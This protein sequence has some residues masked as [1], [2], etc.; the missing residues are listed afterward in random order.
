M[1]I[2]RPNFLLIIS[3][4]GIVC[5]IAILGNSLFRA[6]YNNDVIYWNVKHPFNA[7][8][9]LKLDF[10]EFQGGQTAE[11]LKRQLPYLDW[12]CKANTG[13]LGDR[14]CVDEHLSTWNGNHA[15]LASFWFTND[16]LTHISV[17]IPQDEHSQVKRY[18]FTLL[19]SPHARDHRGPGQAD[20]V[21]WELESGGAIVF[22]IDPEPTPLLWST[23]LWY[24][25]EAVRRAGGLIKRKH[26]AN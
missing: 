19:G 12:Y 17:N 6:L 4:V 16:K 5:G 1:K 25:P 14:V 7:R 26:L 9:D 11:Q 21:V 18:L 22:N 3:L 8:T 23:V 15:M 2:Q 13:G 10:S 20:I 24:S